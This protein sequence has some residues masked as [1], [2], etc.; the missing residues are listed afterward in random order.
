MNVVLGP[1]L[2]GEKEATIRNALHQ[3]ISRRVLQHTKKGLEGDGPRYDFAFYL[4]AYDSEATA[5]AMEAMLQDAVRDGEMG[6]VRLDNRAPHHEGSKAQ[7][8]SHTFIYWVSH[9]QGL[10]SIVVQGGESSWAFRPQ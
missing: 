1:G 8:G 7:A 3:D 2:F 5:C 4:A 6:P 10:S 9:K